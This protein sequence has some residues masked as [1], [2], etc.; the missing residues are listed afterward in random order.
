VD[1]TTWARLERGTLK[2]STLDHIYTNTQG[3][4][5]SVVELL[6]IVSDHSLVMAVLEW[7]YKPI[8]EEVWRRYWRK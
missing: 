8:P 3:L 1:F 2:T 7:N 5:E 6:A 4:I